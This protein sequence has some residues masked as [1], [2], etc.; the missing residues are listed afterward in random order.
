MIYPRLLADP[1]SHSGKTNYEEGHSK[2][3]TTLNTAILRTCRKIYEEGVIY[4]Y[5]ENEFLVNVAPDLAWSPKS[6]PSM[7]HRYFAFTKNLHIKICRDTDGQT[8][9]CEIQEI[10]KHLRKIC[11]TLRS[12]NDRLEN[13]R[14]TIQCA[15]LHLS[16]NEGF[17]Q[18]VLRPIKELRVSGHFEIKGSSPRT[19]SK[20][21][22]QYL[23]DVESIVRGNGL[24]EEGIPAKTSTTWQM[25]QDLLDTVEGFRAALSSTS[26]FALPIDHFLNPQDFNQRLDELSD[27]LE[28]DHAPQLREDPKRLAKIDMKGILSKL[29]ELYHSV[30]EDNDW[31]FTDVRGFSE[32]TEASVQSRFKGNLR[33]LR[34]L[35]YMRPQFQ[36][37]GPEGTP[38]GCKWENVIVKPE[39]PLAVRLWA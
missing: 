14:V 1:Q 5:T 28:F 17:H 30:P 3:R 7:S 8:T 21:T 31:G 23:A 25:Y 37:L 26:A 13:M 22:L 38:A 19:T 35:L 12:S 36:E 4:L 27:M 18:D 29:E 39:R 10:Q 34:E 6:Q 16:H 11:M 32:L 15:G 9:D 20:P 2:P 24:P 33:T